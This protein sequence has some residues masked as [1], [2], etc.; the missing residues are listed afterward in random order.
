MT[1]RLAELTYASLIAQL[2]TTY[3]CLVIS[4]DF[5]GQD[6]GT[7][8]ECVGKGFHAKPLAADKSLFECG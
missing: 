4:V 3:F 8:L 2:S 7:K 6:Y 5:I 1:G